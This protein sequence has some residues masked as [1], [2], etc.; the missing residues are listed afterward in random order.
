MG[1]IPARRVPRG[2]IGRVTTPFPAPLIGTWGSVLIERLQEDQWW[3][4]GAQDTCCGWMRM[5]TANSRRAIIPFY[6]FHI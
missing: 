3:P 2:L 1:S 4:A 5:A 6:V